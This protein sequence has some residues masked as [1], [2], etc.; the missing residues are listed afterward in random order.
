MLEAEINSRSIDW[1]MYHFDII[2]MTIDKMF[3]SITSNNQNSV[4]HGILQAVFHHITDVTIP[5]DGLKS[6]SVNSIYCSFLAVYMYR[7]VG[8]IWELPKC[9]NTKSFNNAPK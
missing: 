1:E 6:N 8:N 4:K 2:I 5:E 7:Y 3:R 9:Q